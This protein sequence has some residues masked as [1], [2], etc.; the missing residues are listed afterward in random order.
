MIMQEKHFYQ[1]GKTMAVKSA[2]TSKLEEIPAVSSDA[3]LR[4]VLKRNQDAIWNR[5][6]LMEAR[7]NTQEKQG[8]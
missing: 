4:R 1:T 6:N 3:D 7:I 2:L 5:L 8:A